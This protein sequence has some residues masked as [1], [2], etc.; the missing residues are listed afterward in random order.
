MEPPRLDCG[1]KI[2]FFAVNLTI[3]VDDYKHCKNK[4]MEA[5]REN[6]NNLL[7]LIL[8]L[9]NAR[10]V[11]GLSKIM[12]SLPFTPHWAKGWIELTNGNY[13]V[14]YSSFRE[15]CQNSGYK[16]EDGCLALMYCSLL[17]ENPETV[18]LEAM[19]KCFPHLTAYFWAMRGKTA[20]ARLIL[21]NDTMGFK[22]T[23][24]VTNIIELKEKGSTHLEESYEYPKLAI[25][26]LI[27]LYKDFEFSDELC[28]WVEKMIQK[29]PFDSDLREDYINYLLCYNATLREA[30]LQIEAYLKYT[31]KPASS[32]IISYV[33]VFIKAG[34][35][36]RAVEVAQQFAHCARGGIYYSKYVVAICSHNP[37]ESLKHYQIGND[38]AKE[39]KIYILYLKMR[40]LITNKA[41]PEALETA[42]DILLLNA[43]YT[44]ALVVQATHGTSYDSAF[45]F[46]NR[47]VESDECFESITSRLFVAVRF[48][49]GWLQAKKD[50]I[51]ALDISP[52]SF[53]VSL[54]YIRVLIELGCYDDAE[55]ILGTLEDSDPVKMLWG[56]LY[57]RTKEYKLA[58]NKIKDIELTTDDAKNLFAEIR[59]GHGDG[60]A[61]V[62]SALS[63]VSPYDN[64]QRIGVYLSVAKELRKDEEAKELYDKLPSHLHPLL[65]LELLDYLKKIKVDKSNKVTRKPPKGEPKDYFVSQPVESKSKS[66]P[67]RSEQPA[68]ILLPGMVHPIVES[69]PAVKPA[70]GIKL[71]AKPR[72]EI[73]SK[74]IF[75][76]AYFLRVQDANFHLSKLSGL[77]GNN[78]LDEKTRRYNLIYHMVQT[79]EILHPT[80]VESEVDRAGIH[81]FSNRIYNLTTLRHFRNDWVHYFNL[82]DKNQL[83][84]FVSWLIHLD[85]PGK[86]TSEKP[87]PDDSKFYL[88]PKDVFDRWMAEDHIKPGLNV[89][90]DELAYIPTIFTKALDAR[91]NFTK[92]G[93]QI[94]AL[95]VAVMNIGTRINDIRKLNKGMGEWLDSIFPEFLV[96]RG[97]VAHASRIN[98]LDFETIYEIVRAA[99]EK[100]ALMI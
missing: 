8:F 6:P 98:D 87:K 48:K 69:V 34:H 19:D 57:T 70:A 80:V 89:I 100:S 72:V 95:K 77:I 74:Y 16:D 62:Y 36:S 51:K 47:A 41:I 71:V 9:L 7:A 54:A 60:A 11:Q 86:S 45:A 12:N 23:H 27:H 30:I 68:H 44:S 22:K 90:K 58:L 64:I 91:D 82:I 14:A 28:L 76:S 84:K 18:V 46:A 65:G 94:N 85:I 43:R 99:P 2:P 73:P 38:V 55:T 37:L 15:Y 33:N 42:D 39:S 83:N 96:A 31:P 49:R 3:S 35:K 81:L 1:P 59:H 20:I 21:N 93:I 4:L 13:A 97:Q 29:S 52:T 67:S 63:N 56:H 25:K 17:I 10:D 24:W 40:Y 26:E 50:A 75:S 32:T 5:Y 61:W 53:E 66:R 88:I 79:I 78:T 92:D